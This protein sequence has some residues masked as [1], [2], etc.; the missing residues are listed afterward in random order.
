MQIVFLSFSVLCIETKM[1]KIYKGFANFYFNY[2][3]T[4]CLW[5]AAI[6][7]WIETNINSIRKDI[8]YVRRACIL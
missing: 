4:I 5:I 6:T 8:F 2:T 1:I 7:Q 3:I